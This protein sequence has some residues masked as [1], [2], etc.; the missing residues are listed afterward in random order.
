[1]RRT[2]KETENS[3][4]RGGGAPTLHPAAPGDAS[5]SH[6]RTILSGPAPLLLSKP[7]PDPKEWEAYLNSLQRFSPT[8]C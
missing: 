7:T 8:R 4:D 5:L 6:A 2:E 1:M 3:E